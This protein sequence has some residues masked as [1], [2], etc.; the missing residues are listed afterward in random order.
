MG[1]AILVVAVALA[2]CSSTGPSHDPVFMS[3]GD[4][5]ASSGACSGDSTCVEVPI[6]GVSSAAGRS[7]ECAIYE[8]PG[9]AATMQPLV[10]AEV[11]VPADDQP[12][13][14]LGV[15]FRWEVAI[16]GAV[17]LD[18]AWALCSPMVEG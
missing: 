3:V 4:V 8:E 18:G 5:E 15:R 13:D 7:G 16:P 2:G 11:E 1:R 6:E 14:E 9:D 12:S 10:D 17:D